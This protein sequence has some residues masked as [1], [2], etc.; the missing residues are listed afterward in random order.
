MGWCALYVARFAQGIALAI[1]NDWVLVFSTFVCESRIVSDSFGA[2]IGTQALLGWYVCRC[3]MEIVFPTKRCPYHTLNPYCTTR[4][5]LP[6]AAICH[7]RSSSTATSGES[8]PAFADVASQ[9]MSMLE[10]FITAGLRYTM[11]VTQ[12]YSINSNQ[13]GT[14]R[15]NVNAGLRAERKVK[16]EHECIPLIATCQAGR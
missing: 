14:C 4:A 10:A 3:A 6:T 2:H 9:N 1:S 16:W 15:C 8:N 13:N 7:K 11:G 12:R 5:A